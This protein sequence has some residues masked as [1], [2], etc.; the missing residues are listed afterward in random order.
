MPAFVRYRHQG[1]ESYG[2]LRNDSV[3]ALD[4]DLWGDHDVVGPDLPL[5]DVTL[6]AP[7]RPWKIIAAAVNYQSHVP[8]GKA[9]LKDEEAPEVPQMFL[10]P[11]SSIIGPG[12]TIV[13][14]DDAPR[15]DAEGELVAVI[16]RVCRSVTEEEALDFVF[17]YTCGNDVSG[18]HWQR[19]D[20]QWWRAKGSDT[21]SPIG[22]AIVTDL[23][24]DD[25]ELRTLV[26]GEE[27]QASSTSQ[28]IHS[29]AKLISFVSQVMTLEP[30][31]L[32]FTGTPGV[33]PRLNDG[34]IVEID[35][36]GIG[37]LKNPVSRSAG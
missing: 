1:V 32:I 10:K 36:S 35:I 5:V 15:V 12:D 6:A 28:M 29:T 25:L 26:N 34:D 2:V 17:G 16:G 14:P 21:F 20:L 4:G 37:V 18:R 27:A 23:V 24:P 8:S 30:G 3:R 19:D 22:P 9:V 7:M 33:P 11:G 31:D 13:L